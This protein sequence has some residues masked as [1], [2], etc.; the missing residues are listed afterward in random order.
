M[1]IEWEKPSGVKVQTNDREEN[2]KKAISLGWKSSLTKEEKKPTLTRAR[3]V[4][5]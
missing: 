1:L 2:I 4:P 3:K 5:E